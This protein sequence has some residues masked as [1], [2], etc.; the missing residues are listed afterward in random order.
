VVRVADGRITHYEVLL[1]M[2]GK[3]GEIH[4]PGEFIPVAE[5]MGLIHPIDLWVVAN[6]IDFLASL[7]DDQAEIGLTVNLSCHAFHEHSLLSLIREKLQ[8]TGV[9]AS[10]VTFEITE[11][12][13]VSNYHQT[14]EM[15]ARIRG[16]GCHFALDDF[17]SGFSSFNYIKRFPVDYL[18]IDG[19]FILHLKENETDQVLVKAMIEIARQL[20]KETVAE[21]VETADVLQVLKKLGVDYVQGYLVGRPQ[22]QLLR[23]ANLSLPEFTESLQHVRLVQSH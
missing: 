2:R 3:N 18:K 23:V 12:A 10:R 17:G 1:R 11:T 19:Q 14:R 16:L 15:I 21:F 6:A 7:A 4:S 8:R 22:P 20:G 13:T 9:A 5:R